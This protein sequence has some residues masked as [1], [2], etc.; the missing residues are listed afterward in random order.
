MTQTVDGIAKAAEELLVEGEIAS[1]DSV[2]RRVGLTKA[3]VVHH[4]PTKKALMFAVLDRVVDRWLGEF[5]AQVGES[6]TATERVRAY[7]E[8][9][10]TGPIDPSDLAPLADVKLRDEL[11]ARW[12]ERF[13]EWFR[14]DEVAE[15]GERATLQAVR[16]LADGAW[17]NRGLN[18]ID[19]PDSEWSRV[20]DVAHGML[21]RGSRA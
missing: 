16:L 18:L 11:C 4:F 3:G 13:D 12:G 8:D 20:R 21:E 10:L 9:A 17:F 14:L 6:S 7:L 1:L 19:L 2:A 5:R 15:V